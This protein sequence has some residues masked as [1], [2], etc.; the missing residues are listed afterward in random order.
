V[1]SNTL[2]VEELDGVA[3]PT[4]STCV[5]IG[6]AG[7]INP[8]EIIAY[9]L[10]AVPGAPIIGAVEGGNATAIVNWTAPVGNGGSMVAGYTVSADD[11]TT[12]NVTTDVCS[13]STSSTATSCDVSGI[14]NGDVYTFSVAAINSIGT[15]SFSGA[16]AA[17]T[18]MTSSGAGGGSGGS[19]GPL[20]PA[21]PPSGVPATSFGT[22]DS[23]TTSLTTPTTLTL[24]AGGASTSVFV[25]A[26]ALP[27]G[28]TVSEYPVTDPSSLTPPAGQSYVIAFAV[29]WQTLGGAAPE[30]T[31]P[32]SMTITD[33]NIGIGDSIYLV[34]SA[35]LTSVAT[36]SVAG[37]VTF[38]FT[39]D[40]VFL[41][42]ATTPPSA[43]APGTVAIGFRLRS[44]TLNSAEHNALGQLATKLAAGDSITVIGYASDNGALAKRRAHEVAAYLLAK[45]K[46]RV[47]IKT[48]TMT[49]ANKVTVTTTKILTA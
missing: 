7:P 23:V 35:G 15:G 11:T 45:V 30:A 32:I 40:P 22:P 42:T 12:S 47:T 21:P 33:P 41:V 9:S 29:S 28:T 10:L 17:V 13:S 14:T 44:S 16:S 3:C 43:K 49:A 2:G 5:A 27:S 24:S 37:T 38:T 26:G 19:T 20:T 36:A 46:V 18:P 25:P 31:A 48:V 34:T 6:I 4:A 8:G 39:S 1:P